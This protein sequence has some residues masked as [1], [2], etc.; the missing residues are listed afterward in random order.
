VNSAL[1]VDRGSFIGIE[2]YVLHLISSGFLPECPR[3]IPKVLAEGLLNFN[4]CFPQVFLF[5]FGVGS[6]K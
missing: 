2:G 5:L 3:T 6:D 1:L 4:F